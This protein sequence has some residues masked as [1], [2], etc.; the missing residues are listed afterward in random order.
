MC[1]GQSDMTINTLCRPCILPF[2][3]RKKPIEMTIFIW[4]MSRKLLALNLVLGSC[5]SS[6]GF[7]HHFSSS[8]RYV[9][10]IF[11]FV[12]LFSSIFH[13]QNQR[14][15]NTANEINKHSKSIL[16]AKYSITF[17]TWRAVRLPIIFRD[18][19]AFFVRHPAP[20]SLLVA[21]P[22]VELRFLK[23]R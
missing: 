17:P 9:G 18:Q 7:T 16:S 6:I 23:R 10:I 19:T 13:L 1:A 5:F 14:K 15:T 4:L 22:S 8:H 20:P 3:A 11:L 2:L 21:S 12:C